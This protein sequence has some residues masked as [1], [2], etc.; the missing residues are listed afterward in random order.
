MDSYHLKRCSPSLVKRDMF[1]TI[2]SHFS[3]N[4]FAKEVGHIRVNDYVGRQPL[5][6]PPC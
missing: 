1:K 3:F 5:S 4:L 2:K 6:Y